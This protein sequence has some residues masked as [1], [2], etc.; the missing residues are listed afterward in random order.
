MTTSQ[1]PRRPKSVFRFRIELKDA[2]FPIWR[3]IDVPENYSFWDLHVAIQDSMGWQDYHLHEFQAT[4]PKSR[5]PEPVGLPHDEVMLPEVLPGWEIPISKFFQKPGDAMEYLY[6]FGDGWQHEVTLAGIILA[7]TGQRYPA[8]VY[9]A[10]ACPPEDCGGVGGYEHLLTVIQDEHHEE[11]SHLVTWLR[12]MSPGN[13]PFDPER[14]DHQAVRFDSPK[15]RL[16]AS[17][18]V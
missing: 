7:E 6:D 15:K 16:R 10:G 18:L 13:W 12:G 1:R 2:P 14:F 11:H 4:R 9:G 3:L 17:G 5:L 8:C